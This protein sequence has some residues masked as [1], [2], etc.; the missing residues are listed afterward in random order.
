MFIQ[1]QL[2]MLDV[3]QLANGRRGLGWCVSS[4][5]LGGSEQGGGLALPP[6]EWVSPPSE[7]EQP[8]AGRPVDGTRMCLVGRAS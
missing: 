7:C 1:L 2:E 3:R 6:R 5:P 8:G 4:G